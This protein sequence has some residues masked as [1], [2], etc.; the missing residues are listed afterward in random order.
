MSKEN[1]EMIF[2]NSIDDKKVTCCNLCEQMTILNNINNNL[3][4]RANDFEVKKLFTGGFI[5]VFHRNLIEERLLK[6]S[7][8]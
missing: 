5:T 7:S 1:E 8:Q 2:L 3:P 4:Q 6:H